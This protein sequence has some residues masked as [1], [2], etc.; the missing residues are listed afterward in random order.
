[1]EVEAVAMS[2]GLGDGLDRECGELG[3]YPTYSHMVSGM[4]WYFMGANGEAQGRC[5]TKLDTR[6]EQMRLIWTLWEIEVAE[7][8]GFEPTIQSPV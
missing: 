4:R 6:E 8:V 5:I 1:M 2:A 3:P 7:G